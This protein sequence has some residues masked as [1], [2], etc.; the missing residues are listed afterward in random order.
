[1]LSGELAKAYEAAN[2]TTNAAARQAISRARRPV[3]KNKLIPFQDRQ[4]FVYLEQQF[5]GVRYWDSLLSAISGHAK[6]TN[7]FIRAMM[8]QSGTMAKNALPAYTMSPA[9]NLKG[10]KRFDV[11]L[12]KLRQSK[13]IDDYNDEY[14]RLTVGGAQGSP[15]NIAR[16][17]AIELSKKMV[18]TDFFDLT[19]KTNMVSYDSG[20]FWSDFGH[21]RW[22]FTAPSYLQGIASWDAKKQAPIPGFILADIVLQRQATTADIS[23]FVEKVCT[24]RSFKNISN[25]VPTLLVYGLEPEAFQLLK[26][27]NVA[28][29]FLDRVFGDTYVQLLDDLIHVL[30][31][32]TQMVLHNPKKIE[33]IFDA[34]AK[35]DGRYNNI[36]GDMFELMVAELYRSIGVGY[37]AVNKE[38]SSALTIS[39]NPK[40]IDVLAER[41]GTMI[42]VECKA[43]RTQI[44]IDFVNEW[45]TAKIPDIHKFLNT[46]HL[47]P[48]KEFEYQLW[49]IGGFTPEAEARLHDAESSA[50]RYKISHY[51]KDKMTAYAK[52]NHAQTFLSHMLKHFS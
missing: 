25:F 39:G 9:N 13:L 43:T 17:K 47:Y 4:V 10:H 41:G 8:A 52:A 11:L 15:F 49:S 37:L 32:A 42:A 16:T 31:Q 7:A 24:I 28:I 33:K 1:M 23:F 35:S 26:K 38:A 46:P 45:L 50:K 48:N 19:R 18:L 20:T 29:A 27:H 21:F 14:Y 3:Q 12:D 44:G 2:Q 6:S 36:V 22:G 51:D 5:T 30:T 40:E 34:L